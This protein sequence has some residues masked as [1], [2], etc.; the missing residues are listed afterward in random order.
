MRIETYSLKDGNYKSISNI[1][2]ITEY[3]LIHMDYDYILSLKVASK[4]LNTVEVYFNKKE[5][6]E[7]LIKPIENILENRDKI[8]KSTIVNYVDPKDIAYYKCINLLHNKLLHNIISSNGTIVEM[9]L[10]FHATDNRFIILESE[11]YMKGLFINHK[12]RSIQPARV[13][14]T[15]SEAQELLSILKSL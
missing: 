13:V 6:K 12:P 15:I 4:A 9:C 3:P 14:L 11:L 7:S 10:K 5:L 8:Y 2:K 1:Q